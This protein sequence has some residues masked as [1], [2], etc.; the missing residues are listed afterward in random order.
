VPYRGDGT[1]QQHHIGRRIPGFGAAKNAQG[2][3]AEWVLRGFACQN[4][5]KLIRA[6]SPVSG[7]KRRKCAQNKKPAQQVRFLFTPALIR[8]IMGLFD[9]P[10]CGF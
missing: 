2:I 5:S 10:L 3:E 9:N 8:T 7:A 1:G 6:D 4:L